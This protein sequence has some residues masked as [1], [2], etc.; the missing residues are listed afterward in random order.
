MGP[1]AARAI[2]S[3]FCLL[4]LIFPQFYRHA[5]GEKL[6]QER[7]WPTLSVRNREK[8]AQK[9]RIKFGFGVISPFS[10]HHLSWAILMFPWFRLPRLPRLR[11]VHSMTRTLFCKEYKS[12][13]VA[14]LPHL[15]ELPVNPTQQLACDPHP[16]SHSPRARFGP[17]FWPDFELS[18]TQ[19]WLQKSP[20][21]AR[22][23]SQVSNSGQNRVRKGVQIGFGVR[24][25]L[26]WG[27]SSRSGSESSSLEKLRCLKYLAFLAPKAP[28]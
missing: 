7:K 14:N 12:R 8:F 5:S 18:L 1:F 6:T 9:W 26:G 16:K 20:H 2:F 17:R 15:C 27:S 25:D 3:F 19:S 21:L 22:S 28:L 4:K 24:W 10:F 11:L 23:E 13:D